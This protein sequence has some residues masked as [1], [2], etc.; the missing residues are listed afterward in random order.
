MFFYQRINIIDTL[1]KVRVF[2]I[3]YAYDWILLLIFWLFFLIYPIV[4]SKVYFF[5]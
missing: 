4:T 5:S 3:K 1:R 2:Y